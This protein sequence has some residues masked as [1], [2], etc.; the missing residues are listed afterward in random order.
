MTE[1]KNLTL[2]NFVEDTLDFA[3]DAELAVAID[4]VPVTIPIKQI[5]EIDAEGKKIVLL[6][7]DYQH[8]MMAWNYKPHDGENIN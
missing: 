4:G 1:I 8:V 3:M 7:I 6:T 5:I 2:K